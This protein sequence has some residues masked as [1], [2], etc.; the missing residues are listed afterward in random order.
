M[1]SPS[2]AHPAS[3]LLLAPPA[4]SDGRETARRSGQRRETRSR[5]RW[6]RTWTPAA[7][8]APRPRA[9]WLRAC[10]ARY[11]CARGR[12]QSAGHPPSIPWR[13][14]APLWGVL[15]AVGWA[16]LPDAG[17]HAWPGSATALHR[18]CR[19]LRHAGRMHRRS[20]RAGAPSP[21]P[22]RLAAQ[23]AAACPRARRR[24][25]AACC[26]GRACC[27]RCWM[28]CRP[29]RPAAPARPPPAAAARPARWRGCCRRAAAP[30]RRGAR[31][32]GLPPHAAGDA[33]KIL[34]G[35]PAAGRCQ[36][37]YPK[38]VMRTRR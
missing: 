37:P 29:R 18:V 8:A 13:H 36:G 11:W 17:P 15:R 10:W 19:P 7:A 27:V 26:G 5:H 32:Q 16:C 23:P 28:R 34:P 3:P 20:R 12:R 4:R 24:A 9:R 31:R 6:L 38:P 2:Y 22:E 35:F 14:E 25:S 33:S 21:A 1:R 30:A